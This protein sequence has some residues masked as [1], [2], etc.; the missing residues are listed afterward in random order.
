[1]RSYEAGPVPQQARYGPSAPCWAHHTGSNRQCG[2]CACALSFSLLRVGIVEWELSGRNGG[3][4]RAAIVLVVLLRGQVQADRD[5][6]RRNNHD[7][8]ADDVD[9]KRHGVLLNRWALLMGKTLLPSAFKCQSPIN[10]PRRRPDL[11]LPGFS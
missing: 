3:P 8:V 9:D 2:R 10:R 11:M 7:A 6:H 4:L 1:R 5:K